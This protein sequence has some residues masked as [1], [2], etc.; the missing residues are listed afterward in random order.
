MRVIQL[1]RGY[2]AMVDDEDYE[3]VSRWRWFA[4]K[5]RGKA[6]AVRHYNPPMR[7]NTTRPL[8]YEVLRLPQPLPHGFCVDHINR[9][10]LDCRKENLRFCTIGQNNRNRGP[11]QKTK[12]SRYKGVSYDR[13]REK[14][15]ASIKHERRSYNLG[16][17]ADEYSAVEAYNAAATVL[18]GRYGYVNR[19][20]GETEKKV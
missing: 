11:M 3:R 14:W 2:A 4:N 6:Y 13:Q 17:Y 16:L 10:P 5:K 12:T 15:A 7:K 18:H 1:T 19:W 9:D 8:A 20:D